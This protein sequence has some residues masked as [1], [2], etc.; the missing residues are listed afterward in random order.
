[1]FHPSKI[2]HI[3]FKY[4]LG[5]VSKTPIFTVKETRVMKPDKNTVD[6]LVQRIVEIVMPHFVPF[7]IQTGEGFRVLPYPS[8]L[9]RDRDQ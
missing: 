4:G 6:Q 3:D 9:F 2:R 5:S 7:V 1:M 8:V